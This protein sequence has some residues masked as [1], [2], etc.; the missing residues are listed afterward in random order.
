[1]IKY[2]LPLLLLAGCTSNPYTQAQW[3]LEARWTYKSDYY[4][5]WNYMAL[6]G[7]VEGDCEDFALT[8]QRTLGKGAVW[9]IEKESWG[10]SAH[11]VL[12][13]DGMFY[14]YFYA[15]PSKFYPDSYRDAYEVT[16][17]ILKEH[18]LT[19]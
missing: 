10:Y 19:N 12:V 7:P 17:E 6:E 11:A 9:V 14:D 1:M 15:Y 4:D 18:G 16:P 8:L 5:E 3:D 13:I 2:L